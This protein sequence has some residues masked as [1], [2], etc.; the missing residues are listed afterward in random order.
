MFGHNP[1]KPLHGL[2]CLSI[3]KTTLI[4]RMTVSKTKESTACVNTTRRMDL[5]VDVHFRALERCADHEG[6]VSELEVF[7]LQIGYLGLYAGFIL[8]TFS[9]WRWSA[10]RR[11]LRGPK[12]G[13][14]GRWVLHPRATEGLWP[15]TTRRRVGWTKNA[16]GA[17]WMPWRTS[18]RSWRSCGC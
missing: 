15:A 2:H 9:P 10:P 11:S 5:P 8:T 4:A 12:T 14:Q 18:P 16:Q 6:E 1:L 17:S 3:S 13:S 7:G